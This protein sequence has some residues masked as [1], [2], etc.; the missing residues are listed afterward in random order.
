MQMTFTGERYIPELRGKIYYEHF[1]RYAMV[2]ELARDKDVLDIACGEGYGTAALALV[3]RSAIGVDID[4]DSIRHAAARYT[5]MNL[6]FRLGDC[7]QI[8]AADASVDVVVSF[9]T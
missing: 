8:P 5:A 9:E 1:H 6:D 2:L 7:T 4:Q 3:A